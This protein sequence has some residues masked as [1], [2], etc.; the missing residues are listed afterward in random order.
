MPERIVR[1]R[2][3]KGLKK[4]KKVP[5]KKKIRGTGDSVDK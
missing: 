1:R 4:S 3:E 5:I 2:E